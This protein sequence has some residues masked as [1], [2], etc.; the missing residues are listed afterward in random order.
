MAGVAK[1]S[2]SIFIWC[3]FFQL[4]FGYLILIKLN[5]VLLLSIVILLSH[6]DKIELYFVTAFNL[7]VIS[8]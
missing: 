7:F 4:L 1:N 2:D 8:F 5:F 3:Y 6:A